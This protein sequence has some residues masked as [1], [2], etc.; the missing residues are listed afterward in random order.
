MAT[1]VAGQN[2]L[3][4]LANAFS[5]A[6]KGAQD[7]AQLKMKRDQMAQQQAQF[8]A[9]LDLGFKKL[10]EQ[11][12]SANLDREQR[13]N[14]QSQMVEA[15]SKW[16]T[17]QEEG[18]LERTQVQQAGATRRK[19]MEVAERRRA[20]TFEQQMNQRKG[21]A[22]LQFM[23]ILEPLASVP[24]DPS[25]P[26]YAAMVQKRERQIQEQTKLVAQSWMGDSKLPPDQATLNQARAAVEDKEGFR[27]NVVEEARKWALA[28][29]ARYS[30]ASPSRFIGGMPAAQR[31]VDAAPEMPD[32]LS[33]RAYQV[34]VAEDAANLGI[35]SFITEEEFRSLKGEAASYYSPTSVEK[36]DPKQF[37]ANAMQEIANMTGDSRGARMAMMEISAQMREFERHSQSPA[38]METAAKNFIQQ[39]KALDEE[40][41]TTKFQYMAQTYAQEL[42]MKSNYPDFMASVDKEKL[43]R[44]GTTAQASG[45]ADAPGTTASIIRA[46]LLGGA[47][48][49]G[50]P[51]SEDEALELMPK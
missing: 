35:P 32:V 16:V 23:D 37:T 6:T 10:E 18:A 26:T 24:E 28:K 5:G 14:L 22:T 39:A 51:A 40:L 43:Y 31:L 36:V 47:I 12:N 30:S 15:R 19:G 4:M 7:F 33:A 21:S 8:D 29:S 17:Q 41:G 48:E 20:R 49:P 46:S 9:Q 44:R 34:N 2:Q 50:A 13:A 3:A 27:F 45:D 38:T 25:D 11:I 1:F 42:F